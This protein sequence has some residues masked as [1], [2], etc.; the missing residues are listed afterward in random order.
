[1]WFPIY[2]NDFTHKIISV[3]YFDNFSGVEGENIHKNNRLI[4]TINS[5][6]EKKL[7]IHNSI[8]LDVIHISLITYALE[9]IILI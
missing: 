5:N 9:L 7:L 2:Y 8:K 6:R 4:K 1:M 3:T